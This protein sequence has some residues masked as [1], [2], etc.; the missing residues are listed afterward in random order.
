M[1]DNRNDIPMG[2][3][4]E[5]ENDGEG[6][7]LLPEGE[8]D[9]IVEDFSRGRHE[10][11]AKLHPCPKAEL[12]IRLHDKD[13]DVT[14]N[15]NL[16]LNRKC[17]W[18]LCAFFTA[19]KHRMPGEALRMNWSRVKGATGRCKVGIRKWTDND[20]NEHESNEI[21]SFINPFKEKYGEDK[22]Q[23]DARAAYERQTET[24][25]KWTPGSFGN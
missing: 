24:Q 2:W 13:G 1:A 18:A 7:R 21:T 3:D 8:Y 19:I 9:F 12:T 10:G 15:H 23:A 4:D 14:V 6:F 16:F 20:G 17:E 11:S 5:I 25:K 22:S